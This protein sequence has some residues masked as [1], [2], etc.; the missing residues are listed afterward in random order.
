MSIGQLNRID[1]QLRE[2]VDRGSDG[3]C[4]SFYENEI[5]ELM[6]WSFPLHWHPEF[7]I[8]SAD[9]ETIDVQLGL[10]HV[11]LYPGDSILINGNVIHGFR[12]VSGVEP[13]S[14]PNVVFASSVVAAGENAVYQKYIAPIRNAT[15]LPYI[16]FRNGNAWQNEVNH[17]ISQ[18]YQHMR[19][20]DKC[21]EMAVQRCLSS[22]F[23]FVY[24]YLRELPKSETTRMQLTA[25]IRL[26]QMLTFIRTN[27][28]K[29]L[30]LADIA[31][32]ANISRSEAGRCF[33]SYLK[34]SPMEELIRYRI[35][36]AACML[37]DHS[38]PIA[39]VSDKCGFHSLSYFYRC[40]RRYTGNTPGKKRIW[41]D[42][43]KEIRNGRL[44]SKDFALYNLDMNDPKKGER[45]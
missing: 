35:E 18:V 38:V 4:I 8:V 11:L 9:R 16:V 20:R 3:F 23:E 28:A 32:S 45:I 30:T 39:E 41:V 1:E 37:N 2:I 40:F 22:V 10:E 13:C 5:S 42:S 27:Y 24:V 6:D 25:Q 44:P 33:S 21:Y 12:Q 26:Q 17:L 15:D 36:M 43:S 29:P 19:L 14:M 7:E 31:A 34:H